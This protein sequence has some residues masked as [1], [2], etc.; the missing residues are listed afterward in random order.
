M[1]LDDFRGTARRARERS[2]MSEI[3]P[4]MFFAAVLVSTAFG[5]IPHT[6]PTQQTVG[7]YIKAEIVDSNGLPLRSAFLELRPE[8]SR[9]AG[10]RAAA[11]LEGRIVIPSVQRGWYNLSVEAGGFELRAVQ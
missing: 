4:V 10:V 9:Q 6:A 3:R 5:Q 7:H 11:S 8:E 1:L 2:V